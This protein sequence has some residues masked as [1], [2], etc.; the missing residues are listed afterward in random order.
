MQTCALVKPD[1]DAKGRA[2]VG[3][4]L[5]EFPP[6]LPC[7]CAKLLAHAPES[8]DDLRF[9]TIVVAIRQLREA[10]KPIA[11]LTVREEL[12]QTNRLD[13]AG[14]ALFL[15]TLGFQAVGVSIAEYEATD[16]W[17][18]YRTRRLKS[19]FGE[20]FAAMEADPTRADAIAAAV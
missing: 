20:A 5:A 15:D 13:D 8:F 14:G 17:E 18:A 9:G 16:L 4:L 1:T 12:Q 3:T 6:D 10:G 11:P 2:V 7:H 19:V